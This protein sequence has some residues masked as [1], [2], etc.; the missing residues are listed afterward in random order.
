MYYTV[1]KIRNELNISYCG[2]W[3]E[4]EHE[5]EDLHFVIP[6]NEI[7]TEGNVMVFCKSC[8]AD[9]WRNKPV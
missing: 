4:G 6:A 2:G 3:I 7:I 9:F 8:L 1:Y 5:V